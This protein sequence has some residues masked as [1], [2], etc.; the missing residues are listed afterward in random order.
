MAYRSGSL[1]VGDPRLA[2]LAASVALVSVVAVSPLIAAYRVAWAPA[3]LWGAAPA[4]VAIAFISSR[5]YKISSVAS[6]AV[7]ISV[8]AVVALG[9]CQ[10]NVVTLWDSLDS[11]PRNLLSETLPLV[12]GMS[13]LVPL[14]VVEWISAAISAEI[15]ARALPGIGPTRAGPDSPPPEVDATLGPHRG[16]F[17]LC[18]P[19]AVYLGSVAVAF[20]SPSQSRVSGPELLVAMAVAAA[21]IHD[22]GKLKEQSSSG[23]PHS[24]LSAVDMPDPTGRYL[25]ETHPA[26]RRAGSSLILR[27]GPVARATVATALVASLLA[28]V[29]PSSLIGSAK[30]VTLRLQARVLTPVV[31]DP[32]DELARLRDDNGA[33]PVSLGSVTVS[34]PH[35]RYLQAAVLNDYTGGLWSF[36]ATFVPTGGRIPDPS[37]AGTGKRVARQRFNLAASWPI[38]LLPAV[39]RPSEVSGVSVADDEMTGMILKD[40]GVSAVKY[41]V[42]SRTVALTFK[43]IPSGSEI[44]LQAGG[45]ADIELPQE[46][47]SY[48]NATVGFLAYLTGM[49]PAASVEFLE[50]ALRALRADDKWVDPSISP[51]P[52]LGGT[53]LAQVINAVTVDRAA[54][55]EQFATFFAVAARLLGVPSRVVTG[56]RLPSPGRSAAP[57]SVAYEL[58]SSELWTWVEIPV[59]GKGWLVA[60]PTP[61]AATAAA[62]PPPEP[63]QTVP[64]TV[65]SP[66]AV[67]EPSPATGE[68]HAVAPP[69]PAP[70]PAKRGPVDWALSVLILFVVAAAGAAVLPWLKRRARRRRR[71]AADPPGQVVGAWSEIL[72]LAGRRGVHLPEASTNAEMAVELAGVYGPAVLEPAGLVA[73]LAERAVFNPSAPIGQ[74]DVEEL[75]QAESDV[76][77]AIK[78]ESRQLVGLQARR[79]RS[80]AATILLGR[81]T[82]RGRPS[83]RRSYDRP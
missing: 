81:S 9:I 42:S 34:G 61:T 36:K 32:V 68:Q 41:T 23:F 55:P 67:A 25:V 39:G 53:S 78:V 15:V 12:G 66:G 73:L 7:S 75:W 8:L 19:L 28:V 5:R 37:P 71:V 38:P 63:A 27:F 46:A 80:K 62:S 72:E 69:A 70:A 64:T 45:R 2:G 79:I 82:G 59:V 1:T 43:Q 83:R 50:A 3:V 16:V 49:R 31:D 48:L 26:G 33:R 56:I 35:T 54:T 57:A 21:M 22:L 14:F 47:Q 13:T 18:V 74:D 52:P 40:D 51:S 6:L 77:A 60:D 58:N 30:P 29:V 24:G 20:A 11:G 4:A 65:A 10:G 76:R 17:A 44:D